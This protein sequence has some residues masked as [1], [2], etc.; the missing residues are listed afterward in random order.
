MIS[1][2]LSIGRSSAGGAGRVIQL[3]GKAAVQT[4]EAHHDQN[5]RRGSVQYGD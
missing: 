3:S 2:K 4:E 5:V 1:S